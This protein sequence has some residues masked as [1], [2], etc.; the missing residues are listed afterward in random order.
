MAE[1]INQTN[2]ITILDD[3]GKFWDFNKSKIEYSVKGNELFFRDNIRQGG[4][5]VQYAAITSPASAD[6]YALRD[7]ITAM[8]T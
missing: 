2:F 1:I 3:N 4:L 8:I 7:L 6:I 5:I